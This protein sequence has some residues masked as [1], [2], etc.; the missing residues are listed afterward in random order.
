[1]EAPELGVANLVTE[2]V[3][4]QADP[5]VRTINIDL[6]V[7]YIFVLQQVLDGRLVREARKLAAL[8]SKGGSD[9]LEL[10]AFF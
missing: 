2:I 3:V 8:G 10:L 5:V 7:H 1:V 6:E 4:V 9:F